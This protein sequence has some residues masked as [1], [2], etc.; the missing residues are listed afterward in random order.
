MKILLIEDDKVLSTCIVKQLLRSGIDCDVAINGRDGLHQLNHYLYDMVILDMI[1]P[2]SNGNEIVQRCR[3]NNIHMPIIILTT[4][5]DHK[6]KL[7]GFK[8]GADDYMLKPFNIEELIA[9]IHAIARRERGYSSQVIQAGNL[10]LDLSEKTA[11]INNI[12]LNLTNKEYSVLELLVLHQGT[13]LS[14]DVFFQKIYSSCL[15]APDLKIID[16]FVC[17]LR[18]KITRIC[19][20]DYIKTEWGRGYSFKIDKE[21]DNQVYKIAKNSY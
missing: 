5:A 6:I 20:D 1:L 16:V 21:L 14:K 12:H 11:K 3:Q 7:E 10:T 4:V 17:K 9:R 15:D 8:L 19:G 18:N 13:T 2:D